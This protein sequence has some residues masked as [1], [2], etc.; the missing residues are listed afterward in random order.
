VILS[1]V[2]GGEQWLT[3]EL[4]RRHLE[5]RMGWVVESN[6]SQ[7]DCMLDCWEK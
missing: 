2:G 7:E 5:S 4:E 1:L 3:G 6:K